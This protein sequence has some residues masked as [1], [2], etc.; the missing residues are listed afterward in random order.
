MRAERSSVQ[1]LADRVT[2][3]AT[4]TRSNHEASPIPGE[5]V[6]SSR[7]CPFAFGNPR[8]VSHAHLEPTTWLCAWCASRGSGTPDIDDAAYVVVVLL[9]GM[10]EAAAYVNWSNDIAEFVFREAGRTAIFRVSVLG[11]IDTDHAELAHSL[12]RQI[13]NV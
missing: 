1:G 5:E 7:Q 13:R 6:H 12:A 9:R 2:A 3:L 10:G 4:A 11:L 8:V